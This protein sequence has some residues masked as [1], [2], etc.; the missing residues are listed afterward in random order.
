MNKDSKKYSFLYQKRLIHYDL[1]GS[2]V[3]IL[4]VAAALMMGVIVLI[5]SYFVGV[6]LVHF[7]YSD[8]WGLYD[9]VFEDEQ[10]PFHLL[11]MIDDLGKHNNSHNNVVLTVFYYFYVVIVPILCY[12]GYIVLCLMLK[13]HRYQIKVRSVFLSMLSVYTV[14]SLLSAVCDVICS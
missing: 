8:E 4:L 6:T 3:R 1:G 7:E 12:I 13:Y 10:R 5:L 2:A 9:T 14:F 11:S